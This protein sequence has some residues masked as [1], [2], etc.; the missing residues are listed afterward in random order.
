MSGFW[1]GEGV[2]PGKETEH[3]E[4]FASF[5]HHCCFCLRARSASKFL[6]E[7]LW[8]SKNEDLRYVG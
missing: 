8:T 3:E 6:P 1:T 2:G 7:K 4:E 5:E